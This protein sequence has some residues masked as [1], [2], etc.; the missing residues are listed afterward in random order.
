V[1]NQIRSSIVPSFLE[2]NF[3]G[4]LRVGWTVGRWRGRVAS[5][6]VDLSNFFY[7]RP[8]CFPLKKC[9]GIAILQMYSSA[10]GLL[11]GN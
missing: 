9:G 11:G 6:K 10:A 4:N 3:L 2:K 8:L 1:K 7:F 5:S